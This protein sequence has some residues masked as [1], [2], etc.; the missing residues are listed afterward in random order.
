MINNCPSL[1]NPLLPTLFLGDGTGDAVKAAIAILREKLIDTFNIQTDHVLWARDCRVILPDGTHL[2]PETVEEEDFRQFAFLLPKEQLHLIYDKEAPHGKGVTYEYKQQG[3]DV[4]KKLNIPYKES[5]L[6]LEGG[7]CFIFSG[8]DGEKRAIIGYTSLLLSM[9][10]LEA[11]DYFSKSLPVEEPVGE[12]FSED[13]LRIARNYRSLQ[14]FE[15]CD[16]FSIPCDSKELQE[17]AKKIQRMFCVTKQEIARDLG[18]PLSQIVFI[19]Q[20]RFHI[21]TEFFVGPD[22]T[23]FLHDESKTLDLQQ[24]IKKNY[25]VPLFRRTTA[26]CEQELEPSQERLQKNVE[27]LKAFGCNPVLIPGSLTVSYSQGEFFI[28]SYV[29][30]DWMKKDFLPSINPNNIPPSF[31]QRKYEFLQ[32]DEHITIFNF[33]NGLFIEGNPPRFITTGL[34]NHPV[35][36]RFQQAFEKAVKDACPELSVEFLMSHFEGSLLHLGGGIHCLTNY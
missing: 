20:K 28:P 13:E 10:K 30:E 2:I 25:Y 26:Y 9:V 12:S 15:P 21:D 14:S 33:M 6:C 1:N 36:Q 18:L 24:D 5:K 7:N 27:I 22:N 32:R 17:T 35:S 34:P 16:P 29:A 4:A 11:M 8:A 31:M 23:V 19:W 3:I